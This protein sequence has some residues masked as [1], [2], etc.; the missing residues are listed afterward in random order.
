LAI[1]VRKVSRRR[2]DSRW[3][4]P[5]SELEV[6]LIVTSVMEDDR[7]P[8]FADFPIPE[9]PISGGLDGPDKLIRILVADFEHSA[10]SFTKPIIGEHFLN[11]GQHSLIRY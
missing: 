1:E 5:S 8:V 6:A 7:A 10:M 9:L 4:W 11:D 3:E 2:E